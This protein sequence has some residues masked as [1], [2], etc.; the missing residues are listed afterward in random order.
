M[1]CATMVLAVG[2]LQGLETA[3]GLGVIFLSVRTFMPFPADIFKI[4][5]EQPFKKPYGWAVWA[6]AGTIASITA[7]ASLS[8]LLSLAGIQACLIRP[9]L[10]FMHCMFFSSPRFYCICSTPKPVCVYC[11]SSSLCPVPVTGCRC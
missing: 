8:F 5:F 9:S 4:S 10:C 6:A 2:L 11:W 1:Q 7:N 3:V